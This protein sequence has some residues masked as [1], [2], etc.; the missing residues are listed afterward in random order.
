MN[1]VGLNLKAL[2]KSMVFFH[3]RDTEK[4]IQKIPNTPEFTCFQGFFM[5]KYR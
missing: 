3:L 4:Q 1:K 2:Y 5:V